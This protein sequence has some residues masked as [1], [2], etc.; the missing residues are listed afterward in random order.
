MG[1]P[2]TGGELIDEIPEIRDAAN[3]GVPAAQYIM[4]DLAANGKGVERDDAAA[5]AF[6]K[7]AADG[8]YARAKYAVGEC[9]RDGRGTERDVD[10]AVRI[11]RSMKAGEV[12][13]VP[14]ALFNLAKELP[15]GA[16]QTALYAEARKHYAAK[17]EDGRVDLY[18][19]GL[20]F[21]LVDG[22][23]GAA[24]PGCGYELLR[25]AADQGSSYAALRLGFILTSE[26][27]YFV[28]I[29]EA[30]GISL[31]VKAGTELMKRAARDGY[32]SAVTWCEQNGVDIAE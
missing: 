22:V 9:L 29:G 8:G 26:D 4:G 1:Q 17:V 20:G 13:E 5:F 24:E 32:P 3:A 6:Y 12:A 18:G 27:G 25:E 15:A 14:Q 23:G 2:S 31:D 11:W 30:A 10:E 21:M 16:E 7:K 19:G 28:G